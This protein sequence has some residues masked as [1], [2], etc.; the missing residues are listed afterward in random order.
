MA[1][2][3]A[4]SIRC[5]ESAAGCCVVESIITIDDRGQMVLPKELRDRAAIE[6][7]D[8]FA[9]TS[10]EKNNRICCLTLTR[11]EDLSELM[12]TSLG[13]VMKDIF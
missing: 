2:K 5:R 3:K 9:V 1:R 10:W 6:A 13:P 7:G 11:V 8:R 12:K 4:K